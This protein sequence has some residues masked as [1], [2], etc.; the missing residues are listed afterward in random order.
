MSMRTILSKFWVRTKLLSRYSWN[1]YIRRITISKP[2]IFIVGCGHTGTSLVLAI[3]GSHSR[4]WAI[5]YESAFAFSSNPEFSLQRFDIRAIAEGKPR[6][7]EK[8]PKHIHALAQ[9]LE[10]CPN[11]KILL[12][13]RDGRDVACS[14]RDRTGSIQ[15]GIIRWV[16]DNRAGR[17][18][19][20]HPSVYVFTYES[21]IECFESTVKGV[22]EFLGEEY[23]DGVKAYHKTPRYYYSNKIE[24]PETAFGKN[25]DQ[26]CNWQINQPLF[27][28]NASGSAC[29]KRKSVL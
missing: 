28:A 17:D 19:C 3:P 1:R 25:H 13:L 9:L 8:T 24:K 15:A 2:P 18:F 16:E 29:Q 10:L 23:E 7:V 21:L 4:I 27:D 5:P 12:L 26:Y 6:W 11:T 20:S 22:L 14:I